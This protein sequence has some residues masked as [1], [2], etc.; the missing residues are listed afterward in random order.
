MM[1]PYLIVAN[2]ALEALRK[3]SVEFGLTPS[4][5]SRIRVPASGEAMDEFDRFLE[6]G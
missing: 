1:S 6:T 5:R 3:F 4:S 2:R